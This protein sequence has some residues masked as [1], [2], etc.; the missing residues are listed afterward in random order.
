MSDA[1][2]A[3]QANANAEKLDRLVEAAQTS[4]MKSRSPDTLAEVVNKSTPDTNVYLP[5]AKVLDLYGDKIPSPKDGLLGLRPE[6]LDEARRSGAD[7]TVPLGD[8]IARTEPSTYKALREDLRLQEN[9]VSLSEAAK[10]KPPEAPPTGAVQ[11][12]LAEASAI[13]DQVKKS[14]YFSLCLKTLVRRE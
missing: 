2:H 4:E 11:E 13:R 8:F 12:P 5:A 10:L 6:Q 14:F 7:V 9:G 3:A 1:F